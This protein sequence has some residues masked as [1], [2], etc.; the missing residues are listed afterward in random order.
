[1]SHEGNGIRGDDDE[2]FRPPSER[3]AAHSFKV[4]AAGICVGDGGVISVCDD[5]EGVGAAQVVW[6]LFNGN[7][8][9]DILTALQGNEEV[10]A[11]WLAIELDGGSNCCGDVQEVASL[12]GWRCQHDI[13]ASPLFDRYE[14]REGWVSCAA[15]KVSGSGDV[16]GRKDWPA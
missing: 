12:V 14:E 6:T 13:V 15:T 2:A 8:S 10:R 5:R 11:D 9:G 3:S 16:L 7:D 4:Q 1:M